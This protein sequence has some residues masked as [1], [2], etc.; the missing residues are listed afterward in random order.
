[1]AGHFLSK[2][3]RPNPINR[4]PFSPN[5]LTKIP[6]FSKHSFS[7]NSN[8]GIGGSSAKAPHSSWAREALG[9]DLRC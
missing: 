8:F 9:L 3:D 1:M 2:V 4:L 7:P 6:K 5:T